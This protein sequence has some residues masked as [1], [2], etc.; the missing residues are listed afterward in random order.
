MKRGVKMHM[1]GAR[2]WEVQP[3][4]DKPLS[5][6]CA[7][8]DSVYVSFYKGVAAMSGAMLLGTADF[9]AQARQ[10]QGQS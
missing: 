4:F 6:I 10:S 8:F 3:F 7:L 1:D 5:Q 9:I 2:L